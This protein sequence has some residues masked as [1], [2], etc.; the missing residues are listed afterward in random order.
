MIDITQPIPLSQEPSP[1]AKA[2]LHRYNALEC[3][4]GE[5]EVFWMLILPPTCTAVVGCSYRGVTQH[6]ITFPD[7]T[8]LLLCSNAHPQTSL[9]YRAIL[10]PVEA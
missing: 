8:W 3:L 1:H 4:W 10:L 9:E 5:Q 7:N 6:R 2:F